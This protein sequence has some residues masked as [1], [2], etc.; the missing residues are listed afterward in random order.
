MGGEH[1]K[2]TVSG[3][4]WNMLLQIFGQGATLI[5]GLVLMRLLDPEEFG[6][7][8]MVTVFSGF[9]SVFKDFGLGSSII[10][11]KSIVEIDKHTVFWAILVLGIILSA[12]LLLVAPLLPYFFQEGK[13]TRIAI[14]LS[15]IFIIQAFGNIHESLF[16]KK[17]RFRELFYAG[18]ISILISGLLALFLAF[19]GF[20]VWALV[21][22][23]IT[24]HSVNTIILFVLSDYRPRFF[25]S[26]S[27]LK[28][29]IGFSLPLVGRDSMNYWSRNAD[30]LLIGKYLGTLQLGIYTRAYSIMMLPISRISGMIASVLFPSFSIIQDD[31]SKIKS[32][33]LK[34]L[35]LIAFIVFP[36]MGGLI[37]G[38]EHFILVILGEEWIAMNEV[39]KVLAIIGAIQSTTTL[40]GNIYLAKA[41]TKLAFKINVVASILLVTGF[42]IGSQYSLLILCYIYLAITIFMLLMH[43]Y[44]ISKILEI[45]YFTLFN[46]LIRMFLG[47][48]FLSISGFVFF[49][50]MSLSYFSEL[51]LIAIYVAVFWF[52]WNYLFDNKAINEFGNAIKL[53]RER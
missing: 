6:L 20:G 29:H 41:K 31:I 3:L 52:V 51:I 23:Q 7:I 22:Q 2:Q 39:L 27:I 46:Q 11:K 42:Y 26:Y 36:L 49:N 21:T 17:L 33:F 8:G 25:F 13:I 30:N 9:L 47:G 5:V 14:F 53:I 45:R 40:N 32:I 19:K 34:I 35:R 18:V 37:I 48:M 28:E 43:T 12:M 44:F 38:S 24:L 15:P 10:Q 50:L 16:K 1:K 4:K